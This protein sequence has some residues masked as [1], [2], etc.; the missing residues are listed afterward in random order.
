[1]IQMELKETDT[2]RYENIRNLLHSFQ[3]AGFQTALDNFGVGSSFLNLVGEVPL[4]DVKLGRGFIEK[5]E[6]D[7]RGTAFLKQLIE[8]LKSF[9]FQVV[10]EGVESARQVEVL[11]NAGCDLVQGNWFSM[12]LNT[13]E[14]ENMLSLPGELRCRCREHTEYTAG[15]KTE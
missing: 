12:P 6:K 1:M 14:F 3:Q 13:K 9:G 11:K 8:M 5:C 7:H 10:C 2:I 4:N 15:G